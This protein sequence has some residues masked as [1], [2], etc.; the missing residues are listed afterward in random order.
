MAGSGQEVRQNGALWRI[1]RL[2]LCKSGRHPR[3]VTRHQRLV[4]LYWRRVMHH[5]RRVTL[6]F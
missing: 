5:Q 4:T 1:L 2:L 6:L 3:K